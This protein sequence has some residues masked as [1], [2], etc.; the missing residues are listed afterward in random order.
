[1]NAAEKLLPFIT[2][3]ALVCA[4]GCGG[5]GASTAT[6]KPSDEGPLYVAP[7]GPG[8]ATIGGIN[9]EYIASKERAD[10]IVA[11]FPKL[12]VGQNRKEVRDIMGPPDNAR[13]GV[14]KAM[15]S[16]PGVWSYLYKIKMRAGSPTTSDVSVEIFFD[17]NDKL[18]WA[19]PNHLSGLSEIGSPNGLQAAATTIPAKATPMNLT[20]DICGDR[21]IQNPTAADIRQAVF[22]LD[23][24]KGEAFII[25]GT[26]DQT[27][28]QS[29][30]DQKVGFD[31]EYQESD[32]KHHYRAKEDF[33]AD[34]V[35]QALVSYAMGSDDWK[36]TATWELVK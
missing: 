33:T 10:K 20:L 28:I 35:V 36:K 26:S 32:T 6:T 16:A 12:K 17:A 3:M 15:N 11:S 27:Y 18:H 8:A 13:L 19:L 2:C 9:Y 24:K 21:K 4:A 30:G 29:S 23:T 22:S 31:L 7:E 5:S 25:L 14:G 34:N 1:M